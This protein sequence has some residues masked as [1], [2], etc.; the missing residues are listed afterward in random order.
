VILRVHRFTI[1]RAA[2]VGHPHARARAHHRLERRDQAAGGM[3]DDERAVGRML[4]DVRLAVGHHDH[5]LAEE[6]PL[7]GVLEPLRRPHA[8]RAIEVAFE[9]DA[10][11]ELADVLQDRLELGPVQIAVQHPADLDR[12]PVP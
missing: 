9:T 7:E 4:V 3:A 6:I 10:I 1:G 2:A 11:D 5:A 12:P 8:A